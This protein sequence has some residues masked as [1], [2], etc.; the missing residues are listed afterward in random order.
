MN[1]FNYQ[2]NTQLVYSDE[3]KDSYFIAFALN[4]LISEANS[5]TL[6][7]SG[8]I[9]TSDEPTTFFIRYNTVNGISISLTN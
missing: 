6:N 3:T 5:L 8:F 4:K 9:N 7:S 1:Q 2:V